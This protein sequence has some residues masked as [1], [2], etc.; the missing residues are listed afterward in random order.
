MSA[1]EPIK[2]A[3]RVMVI[4]N[5]CRYCEGYCAVFPAMERRRTFSE[6]DLKYL[7]NLCHNCRDCY[8]ACQYAPPHEFDLN[9][10]KAMG[11]LRLETYQAFS[12]PGV[13]AGLFR[14]NGV[15][16]SLITAFSFVAVLLFSF[17][18][19]MAGP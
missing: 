6:Q 4:C 14:R 1:T 11:E 12:W 8:Y 16:L 5:A 7:A 15:A 2:E 3:E 18:V 9:F 13:F 19:R 10:P 17:I